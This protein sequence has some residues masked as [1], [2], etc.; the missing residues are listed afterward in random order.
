MLLS[1]CMAPRGKQIC[2]FCLSRL[3]SEGSD[4]YFKH[5]ISHSSF[6][7]LIGLFLVMLELRLEPMKVNRDI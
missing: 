5:V 7:A 4:I 1:S 6:L 3:H 2:S